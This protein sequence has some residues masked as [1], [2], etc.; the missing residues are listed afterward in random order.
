MKTTT[1]AFASRA[2]SADTAVCLQQ[3]YDAQDDT[4]TSLAAEK[5][6][7][8]RVHFCSASPGREA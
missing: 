1:C 6:V 5:K 4:A 8:P 3:Y 2:A 7:R